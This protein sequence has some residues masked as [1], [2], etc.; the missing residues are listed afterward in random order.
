MNIL[1]VSPMVIDQDNLDGVARKLLFQ[2]NALASIG[3][4]DRMYLAS[5]YKDEYYAVKGEDYEKQLK[6]E[7]KHSKQLNMFQIYPQIPDV[8]EELS[9][10]AVYF[11][12]MALSWVTNRL[13]T[14]LKKKNIKIVIEIP[15]YPFWKE[16][17][18]DVLTCIKS[19]KITKGISRCGTN[20]VYWFYAHKLKKK[21]EAI[22]TFSNI[23]KLWGNKVIGIANGYNF[24]VPKNEK[25]LKQPSEALNLLIV[26][27]IRDNH[28]ADRVIQGM[29]DYYINGG[30]REIVFHVV[31]DGEVIPKLKAL[32]ESNESTANRV[33]FYGFKSGKQLDAIY[34]MADIGVSALGFH[35]IGVYYCSPLKSKE[36]FAKGLPIVGTTAERD[37]LDTECKAYYYSVSED[38]QPIDISGLIKFYD[39]LWTRGITDC[40]IIRSAAKHFNWNNIMRPVYEVFKPQ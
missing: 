29:S 1:Y 26:A 40:D 8:C 30:E 28:G 34:D 21:I 4:K 14:D 18:M 16:K 6:F 31:G 13:F 37:I 22:V 27:S 23:T 2:K 25:R 36:Y 39:K 33:I 12:V 38:D 32:A 11:R 19:G 35:R 5:F 15:T 3:E 10:D 9:I 20:I 24:V 7:N 17:W